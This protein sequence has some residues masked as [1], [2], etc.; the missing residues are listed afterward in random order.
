[1]KRFILL[2][3]IIGMTI[4]FANAVYAATQTASLNVSATAVAACSVSVTDVNFGNY[5]G[6]VQSATGN[7]EVTC[8]PGVIYKIALDAGQHSTGAD[9][10]RRMSN[11]ETPEEF[12]GYE[13]YSDPDGNIWGDLGYG[14]TYP[15]IPVQDLGTGAAQ[16]HEVFADAY[17]ADVPA[18][19]YSDV[20][21][22][23]VNY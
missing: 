13:L 15:S 4:F 2:L 20:V 14:D 7:V 19:S 10:G 17:A 9:G 22:V 5:V 23:T 3:S 18:G 21:Q 6:Q 8:S 16:N 12:I 11:G 1:M